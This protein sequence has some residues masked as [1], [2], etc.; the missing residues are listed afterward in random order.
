MI[1]VQQY[2]CAELILIPAGFIS[3]EIM[4]QYFDI[5]RS[6]R[7][8]HVKKKKKKIERGEFGARVGR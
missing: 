3:A 6:D 4:E 1:L 8:R 5:A 2:H 7:S